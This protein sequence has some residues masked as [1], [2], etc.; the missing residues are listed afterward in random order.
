MEL[1]T[2]IQCLSL[3]KIRLYYSVKLVRFLGKANKRRVQQ[4]EAGTRNKEQRIRNK[5]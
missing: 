1:Y 4:G 5:E 3:Y 2:V